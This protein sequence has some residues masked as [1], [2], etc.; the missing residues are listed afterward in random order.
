ML[1]TCVETKISDSN[2]YRVNR[3]WRSRVLKK[4]AVQVV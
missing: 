2:F 3:H 1:N 4:R